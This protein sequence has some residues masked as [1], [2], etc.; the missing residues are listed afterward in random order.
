MHPRTGSLLIIIVIGLCSC[1]A[2]KKT[3]YFSHQGMAEM[4]SSNQAPRPVI[5]I[6]DLLS[7]TVSSL[8]QQASSEFNMPNAIG[9]TS[10]SYNSAIA[11]ISGY[12]VGPDGIIKFPR[13]GKIKAIGMTTTELEEKLTNMLLE[14]QSLQKPIVTVRH[15]NFKVTVL[16]EVARPSVFNI[17]NARISLLEAIGMAGDMTIYGRRDNVLL[18]REE[19]G[20]KI[21]VR[22]NLNS[23]D[24]FKSPYYYLKSNDVIYVEPNSARVTGASRTKEI[25]PVVFSALS[26]AVITLDIFTR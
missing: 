8:S 22:I 11:P 21:T 3:A 23:V 14:E 12:L 2:P 26:F 9:F 18:I 4:L 1:A 20:K 17:P 6:N 25:V 7:I 10:M 13:L 15:L 5:E 16:G 24:L 19:S